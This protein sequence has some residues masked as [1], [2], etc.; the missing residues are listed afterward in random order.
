MF[1]ENF[2]SWIDKVSMFVIGLHGQRCKQVFL[3]A[4]ETGD[5][6]FYPSGEVL[7][8]ERRGARERLRVPQ[9]AWLPAYSAPAV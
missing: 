7:I 2:A 1:S 8:A 3:D 4:L 6:R 5:F 9:H